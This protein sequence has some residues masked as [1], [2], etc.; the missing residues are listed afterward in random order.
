MKQ[1]NWK[2][3]NCRLTNRTTS[4]IIEFY[5]LKDH[6]GWYGKIGLSYSA[7]QG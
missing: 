1:Q 6:H 3:M 7:P 5:L 4:N 2:T